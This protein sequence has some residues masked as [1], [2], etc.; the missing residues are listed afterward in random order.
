M[1]STQVSYQFT[2]SRGFDEDVK[3]FGTAL[4]TMSVDA[5]KDSVIYQPPPKTYGQMIFHHNR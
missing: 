2:Q 5:I 1:E 3:S 4:S